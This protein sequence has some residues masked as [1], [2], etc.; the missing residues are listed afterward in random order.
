LRG[1]YQQNSAGLLEALKTQYYVYVAGIGNIVK[2]D[3]NAV[4]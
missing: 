1:I 2:D 4:M 3:V